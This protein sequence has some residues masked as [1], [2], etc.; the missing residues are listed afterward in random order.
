MVHDKKAYNKQWYLDNKEKV[1]IKRWEKKGLNDDYEM[2]WN[3]FINSTHCENLK[4]NV[5]YGVKGD[6]TGTWKC[7]DHDH[8]PG[9]ENNFRNILCNNC[10][11]NLRTDNKSGTPNICKYK[12]GWRYIRNVNGKIHCKQL[13]YYYDAIV[14]KYLYEAFISFQQ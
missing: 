12:N 7:M 4:C 13:K 8:T 9:L 2:V 3:R 14:Y 6:G 5:L 11:V 10:N 1:A